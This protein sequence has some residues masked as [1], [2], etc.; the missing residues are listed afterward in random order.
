M[1]LPMF[2]DSNKHSLYEPVY[3]RSVDRK[4][5]IELILK[6]DLITDL[7]TDKYFGIYTRNGFEYVLEDKTEDC[8]IFL[9]DFDD[10][11]GL[12]KK[13]GYEKVNEILKKTFSELKDYYTIGRAFSGDEIFFLTYDLNETIDRIREVCSKNNLTFTYIEKRYKHMEHQY[14]G[15]NAGGVKFRYIPEILEEMIKELH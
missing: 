1:P 2:R 3:N 6:R 10:I 8:K 7:I 13:I 12:N 5:K 9:I 14:F 15:K 11:R 4:K